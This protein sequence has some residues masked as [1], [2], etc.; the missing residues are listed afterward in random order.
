M[1]FEH[2]AQACKLLVDI[3]YFCVFEVRGQMSSENDAS[4]H[5]VHDMLCSHGLNPWG[6]WLFMDVL[7]PVRRLRNGG[8][9]FAMIFNEALN[10]DGQTGLIDNPTFCYLSYG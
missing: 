9:A 2:S 5:T 3:E 6:S 8:V 10:E 1:R 4:S 7:A